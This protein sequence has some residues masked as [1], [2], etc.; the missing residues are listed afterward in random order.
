MKLMNNVNLSAVDMNLLVQLEALLDEAHVRRAGERVGLSQPAASHA[1][2]RLRDLFG[3]PLL[4]RVGTA[5]VRTPKA[6]ALREPLAEFVA[7]AHALLNREEFNPRTSR[8]TF[9]F[10]LPDLVCHLM[11]PPLL[12]QLHRV[13]PALRVHLSPWRGPAL[14]TERALNEIDFLVTSIDREFKGFARSELFRSEDV[15]AVRD[16]H[17]ARPALSTVKGFQA[18]RHVAVI[19]AGETRDELDEWLDKVGLQRN[20]AVA[21]PTHLLARQVAAATDYVAFVPRR[22]AAMRKAELGLALVEPPIDPGTDVLNLFM[23]VKSLADTGA[24][25]MKAL[26]ETTHGRPGPIGPQAMRSPELP[27]GSLV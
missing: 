1:L 15:L 12:R 25:W 27:V 23:P 24:L 19:G 2:A 11:M 5:M 14:L 4:V 13:A 9:R 3:D 22:F 26:I 8:R 21:A 20:V 6:D 10:M 18:A 17:P 7:S 16:G